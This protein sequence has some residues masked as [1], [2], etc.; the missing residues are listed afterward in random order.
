MQKFKNAIVGLA[1]RR[2]NLVAARPF[3]EGVLALKHKLHSARKN[4][5]EVGT[6]ADTTLVTSQRVTPY[7]RKVHLREAAALYLIYGY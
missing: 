2:G 3:K 4:V 6:I 5:I 7:S 1:N